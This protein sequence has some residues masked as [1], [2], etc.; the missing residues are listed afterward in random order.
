[1][2][3]QASSGVSGS[4][5]ADDNFAYALSAGDVDG[6]GYSDLAVGVPH[7]DVSGQEDQGGVHLFRGGPGGLTG[8]RTSWIPQTVTGPAEEYASFGHT[9]RLR[10]VTKDG[11]ADVGVGAAGTSVILRGASGT[12]AFVLP[13]FG[14][15]FAD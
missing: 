1:M 10:D 5:E 13:E 6:D 3:N 11:K 9:V 14:G 12:G 15:A 8:E 7:E 2:Y 4:P